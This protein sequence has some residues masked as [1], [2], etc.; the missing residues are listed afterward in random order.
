MFTKKNLLLFMLL[1]SGTYVQTHNPEADGLENSSED[2]PVSEMH[3]YLILNSLRD[4]IKGNPDQKSF[5][6]KC[7]FILYNG[8]KTR[9]FDD[10]KD[11]H[12]Q[13]QRCRKHIDIINS[14]LFNKEINDALK[15]LLESIR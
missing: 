10:I 4:Y 5:I 3:Y 11:A 1:G 7:R 2:C 6:K 12:L 15:D 8:C 9:N 14:L 13:S